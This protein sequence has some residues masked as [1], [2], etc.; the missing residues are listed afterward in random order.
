MKVKDGIEEAVRA[1]AASDVAIVCV[2]N[3]PLINGKEEIDRPDLVLPEHQQRLIREVYKAN[4]NTIVVVIGSY[5]FALN[6]EE[7]HVPAIVYTAHGG[8]EAGHALADVLFGDY[9]PAGRLNMTWYRSVDQ[10]PDMMDYDIIKGGRTYMYFEGEP[11]YPFGHGLSYTE[12][13]Y[14]DPS[15]Q[16]GCAAGGWAADDQRHR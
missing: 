12:F 7:E 13:L 9:N 3:Q 11:L 5:P 8:Q 6:W 10:L 16:L 14:K 4:P 1:A 15:S 2:G